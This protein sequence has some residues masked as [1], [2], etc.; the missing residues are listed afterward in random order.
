MLQAKKLTATRSCTR[1]LQVRSIRY[2]PA[3]WYKASPLRKFSGSLRIDILAGSAH[4]YWGI[5]E[6]SEQRT[7][8]GVVVT[9]HLREANL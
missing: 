7:G 6:N 9:G 1:S 2:D 5:R 4:S 8:C 3:D